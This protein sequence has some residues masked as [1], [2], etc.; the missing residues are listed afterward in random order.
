MYRTLFNG[1][2]AARAGLGAVP[3]CKARRL[4]QNTKHQM[5]GVRFVVIRPLGKKLLCRI[6]PESVVQFLMPKEHIRG[7]SP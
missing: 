5:A 7:C 3:I 2:S 6:R 4:Q 1:G